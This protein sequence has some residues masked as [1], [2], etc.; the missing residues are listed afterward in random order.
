M[1]VIDR[2]SIVRHFARVFQ[3]HSA[4]VP[5]GGLRSSIAFLVRPFARTRTLP[6]HKHYTRRHHNDNYTAIN[7]A[8][9][10]F[11]PIAWASS[12]ERKFRCPRRA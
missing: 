11:C 10:H 6:T 7:A 5:R 8:P 2:Q 3:S 1:N 9:D 4:W 12:A